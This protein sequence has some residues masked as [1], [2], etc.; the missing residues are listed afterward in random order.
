MPEKNVITIAAASSLAPVLP[1]L[2]AAWNKQ[3]QPTQRVAARPTFGA[4][5][6][7]LRQ[8][9]AG[10][11]IDIFL[12][13][14]EKEVDDLIKRGAVRRETRVPFAE[15]RLVLTQ[16]S[17]SE[18]RPL[19]W[20]DLAGSPTRYR[21]ALG[22]PDTVPAGRYAKETLQKHGVYDTLLAQK[23]LV[24]T[25]TVRQAADAAATGNVNAAIVFAT[26]VHAD[27]R[28]NTIL[29]AKPGI[30]HK[31]IRYVAILTKQVRSKTEASSFLQFLRSEPAKRVLTEAGFQ[32]P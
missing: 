5:G 8:I 29:T 13:A 10:A 28:L 4:S 32:I 25:G 7:L 6:T 2:L 21:I 27:P 3:K 19:A 11:P 20:S 1:H 15:N 23:R 16:R 26:D 12:S 31:P 30:D 18:W 24:F 9:A 22:K 14:G 17:V